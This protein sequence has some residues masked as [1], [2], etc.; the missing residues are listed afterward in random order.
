MCLLVYGSMVPTPTHAG[1]RM[2]PAVVIVGE[3]VSVL[4][5]GLK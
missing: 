4:W 3:T 2:Q 5:M 1:C